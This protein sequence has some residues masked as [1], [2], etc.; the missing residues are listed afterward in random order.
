MRARRSPHRTH[1]SVNRTL[2][3]LKAHR[4]LFLSVALLCAVFLLGGGARDDIITL[5]LLRLLAGLACATAVLSIRREDWVA[6]R[7]DIFFGGVVSLY[8]AL[9]LVPLPPQLWTLLPGREAIAATDRLAG[10]GDIWRPFTLSPG[11]TWNALGSLLI[12]WA[13]LLSAIQLSKADLERLVIVVLAL[14]GLSALAGILQIIGEPG[15]PFYFYRI[16]NRDAAVGLFSNRNH[17]AIFLATLF[18]ML[19]LVAS[20]PSSSAERTRIRAGVSVT[21]ALLLLPLILIAGSRVGVAVSVL[22]LLSAALVYR[23]PAAFVRRRGKAR[24]DWRLPLVGLALLLVAT[25][26]FVAARAV[27]IDRLTQGVWDEEQ[28]FKVWGPIV[29]Q[30]WNYFPWGAGIGSF[31]PVYQMAEPDRLLDPT[32]LNHAHNEL[33]ELWLTGGLPALLLA[34]TALAALSAQLLGAWRNA[35]RPGG[36]ALQAVGAT[37]LAIMLLGSIADYPLRTPSLA[38]LCVLALL[39]LRLETP[40][41]RRN[42]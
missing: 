11:T 2:P 35:R 28:R 5:P 27:S 29:E 17:H 31:V 39:W 25:I 36:A 14:G 24:F 41:N 33:L 4:A 22:A 40:A 21:A 7:G 13:M 34:G 18:P 42:I 9:Q 30:G 37:T 19:A 15:G 3:N 26:T 1:R 20:R 12:P 23:Q 38:A 32:Y 8:V 16:T 6:H 10:I